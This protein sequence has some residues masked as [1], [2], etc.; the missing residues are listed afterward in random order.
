MFHLAQ[1]MRCG[2]ETNPSRING[3]SPPSKLV[4]RNPDSECS[5]LVLSWAPP[6]RRAPP[7]FFRLVGH[8]LP[9][10]LLWRSPFPHVVNLCIQYSIAPLTEDLHYRLLTLHIMDH[11]SSGL[12]G[13]QHSRYPLPPASSATRTEIVAV[14]S[15]ANPN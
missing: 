4:H 9:A 14:R 2:T 12:Q 13:P 11:G 1:E 5:L 10:D 15:T 6:L 7:V 8:Y 3:R